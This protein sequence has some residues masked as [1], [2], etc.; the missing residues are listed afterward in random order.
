[1]DFNDLSPEMKDKVRACKSPEEVLNLAKEVGYTLTDEQLEGISGG[2]GDPNCTDLNECK[3]Y[4]YRL[5]TI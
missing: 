2:W 3:D 5:N 1:M 4:C